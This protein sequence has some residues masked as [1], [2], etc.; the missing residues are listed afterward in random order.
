MDVLKL[1]AAEREL[2]M[3]VINKTL[4]MDNPAETQKEIKSLLRQL[5][6]LEHKKED[7]N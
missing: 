7:L 1:T 4:H 5:L 2:V 6:I 3:D